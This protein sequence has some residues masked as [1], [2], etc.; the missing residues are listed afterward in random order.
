MSVA[1][2]PGI[3]RS[4]AARASVILK[5]LANERRLVVLNDLAANGER[6]VTE[7]ERVSGLSQ[8]ALSQHLAKM[9][10]HKIV[11]TRR[12]AQTIYY[13]I[14]SEE[15]LAIIRTIDSIFPLDRG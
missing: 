8:S 6:S 4:H 1:H 9:R 7:M 12:D 15:V 10:H 14:D 3:G 13:S 2:E 11:K 5:L